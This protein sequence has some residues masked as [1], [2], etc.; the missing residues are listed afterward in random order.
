MTLKREMSSSKIPLGRDQPMENE[1]DEQNSSN[2]N[3]FIVPY[4]ELT[5]LTVCQILLK[6]GASPHGNSIYEMRP[7]HIAVRRE[8]LEVTRALLAA[9]W[10]HRTLSISIEDIF[11][12]RSKSESSR[13]GYLCFST[14]EHCCYQ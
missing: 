4:E 3:A 10:Y 7:L 9:G 14:D 2:N 6:R 1:S 12:F 5:A 8:W 13:K 11:I